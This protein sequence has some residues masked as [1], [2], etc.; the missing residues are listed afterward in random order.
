MRING[1]DIVSGSER[2]K[3]GKYF[4][5]KKVKLAFSVFQSALHLQK[6]FM[7]KSPMPHIAIGK[8]NQGR[9]EKIN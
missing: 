9:V 1:L 8:S 3:H 7:H 6:R 2:L 4:G 5:V